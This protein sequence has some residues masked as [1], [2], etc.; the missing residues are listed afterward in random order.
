MMGRMSDKD[1]RA[2]VRLPP[3]GP[4]L[5][6]LSATEMKKRF[7]EARAIVKADSRRRK[8]RLDNDAW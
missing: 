4:S 8:A 3:K 6:V 1:F 2:L 7:E 5:E